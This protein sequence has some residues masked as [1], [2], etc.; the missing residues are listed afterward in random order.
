M[1]TKYLISFFAV[2]STSF[3]V[4][5]NKDAPQ[6]QERRKKNPLF[7]LILFCLL[8]YCIYKEKYV[9]YVRKCVSMYARFER[10]MRKNV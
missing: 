8:G 2:A 5:C 3:N 10:K 1:I 7:F 4:L 6:L 9:S